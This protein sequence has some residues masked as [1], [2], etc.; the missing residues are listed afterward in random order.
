M[1]VM[2]SFLIKK[3]AQKVIRIVSGAKRVQGAPVI[4]DSVK[5]ANK[6]V[7]GAVF[8]SLDGQRVAGKA[9]RIDG[10]D[11]LVQLAVPSRDGLL[12]L[13]PNEVRVKH[14]D[15][16][17]TA[18][19]M[20]ERTVKRFETGAAI[21]LA[22]DSKALPILSGDKE[23]VI[24][25]YRDVVIDGYAS[26][27]STINNLD[28]GGDYVQ[29]GAFDKTLADF[30]KNPVILTDHTNEVKYLAGSWEKVALTAKGLAVR[31]RISNAPDVIGTRFKLAE[32]HLKALSIGGIWYYN[33]ED[34]RGIEEADLFEISLV[35]VPMNP[36]ALIQ[37]S[38]VQISD[39]K[40]AFAR[41]WKNNTALREA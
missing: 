30:L 40:T 36:D 13:T 2:G 24:V 41:F 38:A 11:V 22:P 19:M 20:T 16:S 6:L 18:A 14:A 21:E 1:W 39:C 4:L 32:G 28:R 15:V 3:P 10:Q 33:N 37:T 7:G 26:T 27:F 34:H 25:D 35:P 23:G 17:P 29:P 8:F 9:L 5:T 12:C 31:G